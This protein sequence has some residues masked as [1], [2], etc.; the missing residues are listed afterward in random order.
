[1]QNIPEACTLL[2]QPLKNPVIARYSYLYIKCVHSQT[3]PKL[4]SSS[5][6]D[7]Q[8]HFTHEPR[9]VTLKLW[10]PKRKGPKAVATHLQ[11]HV[12]VWSQ[13]LKCSVK[14][15]VIGPSTK[16]YFN[17]FLFMWVLTHDKLNISTVLP[18]SLGFVLGLPPRGDFWKE[19]KWAWHMIHWMSCRSPRRLYIH[20]AFTYSIGLSSV[21]WSELGLAPP[22]PPM[23]LLEVS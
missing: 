1:M 11:N 9:A 17:E 4:R 12:V 19:S 7:T 6:D 5:K 23:G 14:P 3:L 22:F 20:L 15:Y 16:C 13:T 18:W 10:E 21:V 2:H 8:G